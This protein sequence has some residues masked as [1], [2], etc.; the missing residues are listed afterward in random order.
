MNME[1]KLNNFALSI[2]QKLEIYEIIVAIEKGDLKKAEESARYLIKMAKEDKA[3][4]DQ[5][6]LLL[7]QFSVEQILDAAATSLL[8]QAA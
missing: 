4:S 2:L 8:A 5:H 7:S 3:L 1:T 6:K